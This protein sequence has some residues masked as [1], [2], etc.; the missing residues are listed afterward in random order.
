MNG[1]LVKKATKTHFAKWLFGGSKAAF[2]VSKTAFCPSEMA[3]LFLPKIA[4]KT[5]KS[6][7]LLGK[8]KNV[9]RATFKTASK[10]R[11]FLKILIFLKKFPKKIVIFARNDNDPIC[12]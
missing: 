2:W 5:K 10:T 3:F 7:F 9:A 8:F 11:A 6:L 1:G 12:E 4:K